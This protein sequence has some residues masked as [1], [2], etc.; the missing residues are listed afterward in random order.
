MAP[1]IICYFTMTSPWAYLGHD[2]L[3]EIAGRHG[4]PLDY[5]PV[6]LADLFGRTGGLPLPQRHV[7]RQRHRLMEL[8]RWRE[9]R[10]VPLNLSPKYWPYKVGLCDRF[11]I[12]AT[13]AGHDPGDFMLL[14]MRATWSEDRDLGDNETIIEIADRAGLPG[15]RLVATAADSLT[16]VLYERNRERAE[17]DGCFGSPT[18]ILKGEVFWGQDRLELLED[19]L[20]TGREPFTAPD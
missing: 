20:K 2:G 5:R 6:S 8:Q 17:Q 3:R 7:S 1:T 13:E 18:Y 9:K 4:V 14:A 10:N 15:E 19:A 12:A 16:A 11:I